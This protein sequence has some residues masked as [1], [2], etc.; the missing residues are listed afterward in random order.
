MI[1]PTFAGFNTAISALKLN[2][3]AM[4][5]VG[6][7]MANMHTEGYTR[8]RI[9][10]NSIYQDISSVDFNP[11]DAP[12]GM[13]VKDMGVSQQRDF[14][15]DYR[16]RVASSNAGSTEVELGTMKDIEQIFDEIMKDGTGVRVHNFIE[17][18]TRMTTNPSDPIVE[19]VLKSNAQMIVNNLN[20]NANKLQGL[21]DTQ[22]VN[23]KTGVVDRLNIVVENIAQLNEQIFRNG[24]AGNPSLELNDRRNTLIDELSSYVNIDVIR[25]PEKVGPNRHVERYEIVINDTAEPVQLLNGKEFTKLS[26][27]NDTTTGEVIIN[28]LGTDVDGNATET[29]INDKIQSGKIDGYLRIL[30]GS[31]G[32]GN[33]SYNDKGILYFKNMNDTFASKFAEVMNE[34][35]VDKDGVMYEMFESYDGNPISADNIRVAQKWTDTFGSYIVNTTKDTTGDSSGATDNI[36]NIISKFEEEF[37]FKSAQKADETIFK[38]TLTELISQ[39]SINSSLRVSEIQTLNETTQGDKYTVGSA[40]DSIST[41]DLNE[42]GVDLMTY[43]KSYN[44]AA[45]LMTTLDEMLDTLINRMGV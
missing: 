6:Q 1:R 21:Y 38:G 18:L 4:D 44:A 42:E 19:E 23:L 14:S 17:Q 2:Q 37:E 16:Y 40:R 20:D 43:S 36:L 11:P 13:G 7:N 31:G 22:H 39:T 41:V 5:V 45:K 12:I 30:N 35:N 28:V 24:V 10:K 8:Q 34:S 26:V 29:N 33:T 9:D 32:V 25:H 3:K 27:G 15:L